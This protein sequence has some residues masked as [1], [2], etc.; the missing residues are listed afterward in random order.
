MNDIIPCAGVVGILAIIFGF[1]AFLRYMN[2]KETI[3][4]AEKG[5]TK[6]EK[7][8]S[9]GLLR[10]GIIITAIGLAFSIG[11][12]SIGFAS[13]D[14][15]PLHLGPWMLGGFVPLFLGLGL[16]LLHYLTEKE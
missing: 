10:W 2:Y 14:S 9:K 13:A 7:K 6:P 3:I 16:I 5:L 4:L 11:L 8:P 15:Y 12:Y 1:L